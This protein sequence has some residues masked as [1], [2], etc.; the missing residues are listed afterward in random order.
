MQLVPGDHKAG[1]VRSPHAVRSRD[2]RCLALGRDLRLRGR[3]PWRAPSTRPHAGTASGRPAKFLASAGEQNDLTVIAGTGGQVQFIDSVSPVGASL[4]WCLPFPLGQALC[5]PDGDPRDTD[6]GGV[7]VD[8]GDRD[9]RGVIRFIPGTAT[10]PGR[11]SVAA[12]AGDDIVEN[13]AF[14]SVRIDGGEGDDTLDSGRAAGAYLLGGPGADT[15]RSSGECCAVAGYS[16]HGEAGVGITLD[17][18]ANDGSAGEQDDVRTNHVIGSP[19]GDVIT[20][21]GQADTLVGGGG[22]DVI[23]G[24]GGDDTIN[25]TLEYA[26]ACESP[27]SVDGAD[28]VTCGAGD[29]DVTADANDDVAVDCE[30][31][32]LGAP[33]RPADRAR[34]EVRA[35]RPPAASSG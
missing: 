35:R 31:I 2:A 32:R 13:T 17:G 34:D 27:G 7:V 10:R 20:G 6:G 30:R 4:P 18:V 21:G 14:G 23:D 16:D 24:R 12:G 11:I 3:S 15:L 8:L 22:A 26:Q 1:R 9:D 33:G 25:A 19:G 5:D 28:T 29:D